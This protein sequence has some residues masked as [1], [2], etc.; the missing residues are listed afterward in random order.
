MKTEL[1]EVIH[2]YL[3]CDAIIGKQSGQE[4][5]KHL[6]GTLVGYDTKNKGTCTF[7]YYDKGVSTTCITP[8]SI[9]PILRPI[10]DMTQEESKIYHSLNK[11]YPASPV[12]HIMVEHATFETFAWLL[13]KQFDLFELIES[14]QAIDKTKL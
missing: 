5:A 11:L 4:N 3:G 2:L 13:K 7:I 10:S 6:I 1:K 8:T 12:H 14:G 9:K